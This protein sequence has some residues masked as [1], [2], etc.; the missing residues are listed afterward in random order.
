MQ[1][2]GQVLTVLGPIDPSELGRTLTHEHLLV[3]LRA[4]YRPS[5]DPELAVALDGPLTSAMLGDI[6]CDFFCQQDNLVL[7]D[8]DLAMAEA[9][10]FKRAGGGTICDVSSGGIRLGDQAQKLVHLSRAVGLHVLM[11]TGS[12]VARFHDAATRRADIDDLALRFARE[13]EDGVDSEGVRCGIIGEIGLSTPVEPGEE[14]V[15]RAA[16]RAHRRTGAPIV[17]HQIDIDYRIPHWALDVLEEEGVRPDRVVLGHSG[18]REDLAPLLAAMRRGAY[19]A[20]DNI[21]F[22]GY[23]GDFEFPRDSDYVR[24]IRS[25]LEAG[26]S[27]RLLLSQDVCMK[28]HLR[29]YGGY[30]YDH[31]LRDFVPLLRQAG[32]AD[33]VID[34]L[35]IANPARVLALGW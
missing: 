3:D 4:Y 2:A 32:V 25:I 28:H 9:Q 21:G 20:Y 19:V 27:E 6:R 5:P 14:K 17:I 13:V 23:Q 11:G 16:G 33:T 26:L 31:I 18:D 10:R 12:Y 35:L 22:I 29:H 1:D 24:R 8:V 30:G 7:D 34:R 15:L